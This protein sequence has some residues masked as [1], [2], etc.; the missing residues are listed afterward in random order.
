MSLSRLGSIPFRD[1]SFAKASKQCVL[2]WV[3]RQWELCFGIAFLFFDLPGFDSCSYRINNCRF[4]TFSSSMVASFYW[5]PCLISKWPCGGIRTSNDHDSQRTCNGKW[6]MLNWTGKD[7]LVTCVWLFLWNTYLIDLMYNS[8][9]PNLK[10]V[11]F[12]RL[13]YHDYFTWDW[14]LVK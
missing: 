9:F 5:M 8:S 4:A 6:Q 2:D 12:T 13:F 14:E 7:F 1:R 10:A 3:D 11:L